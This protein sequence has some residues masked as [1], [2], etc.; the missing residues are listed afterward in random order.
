MKLK[1]DK[2]AFGIFQD[3]L[4]IK[5][6]QLGVIKGKVRIIRLE[7]TVLSHPLRGEEIPEELEELEEIEELKIPE[8]S[9]YD[10]P[11]EIEKVEEAPEDLTGKTDLQNLLV[12]FPLDKG[13]IALNANE[14][15]ISYYQFEPGYSTS[16]IK[17][18][19]R[20]EILSKEELKAKNYTFDYIYNADKSILAFVHR[21]ESELLKTLQEINLIISKK[22]FFYSFIDTNE[23]SLMNLLRGNY[24]IPSEE[25]VLILYI[26]VDYKVGIVME[27]KN[28]FKTFPII[29]TD[30]E[31]K[32]TREAIYS[33]V[34]LEQ[35]VSNIPMPQ[36]IL[37]AGDNVSKK[38]VTF[39]QKKY[40]EASVEILGIKNVT[41]DES[42]N[43]LE[44]PDKS[45]TGGL[46][47]QTEEFTKEK[48]G[49]FA[50]PIALAW[51]TLD[52]KNKALFPSNLLP[53]KIIESQKHFKIAWHGFLIVA[54]IFYF[55][56][57]STTKNITLKQ[58]ILNAQQFNRDLELEIQQK[59]N[60]I[61]TINQIRSEISVLENNIKQI[62]DLIGNK[63]QWH[64]ILN[65]LANALLENKIS[66]I[67]NLKSSEDNFQI[68]GYTTQKRNIIHFSKLFPN[69]IIESITGHLIQDL[70]IWRYDINFSYPNPKDIEKEKEESLT[71][72]QIAELTKKPPEPVIKEPIKPETFEIEV[73]EV[74]IKEIYNNIVSIYFKRNT[75]DAYE[76]FKEFI[77][78]YPDHKL[79]HN[80]NYLMGECL[81]TLGKISEAKVIFENT[82]KQKGTKTPDALMMLGNSYL[83]ENDINNAI[84]YWN[85]LVTNYPDH[86]LTII[87][88]NKINTFS[89]LD[90][91]Y[92]EKSEIKTEVTLD[93]ITEKS[94][95]EIEIS[96]TKDISAKQFDKKE[97]YELQLLSRRDYSQV[98]QDKKEMEQ[99]GYKTKIT[100]I[101]KDGD[102]FYRLRLY[103]SC[104]RSE[105]IALG[106]KIKEQFPFINNYWIEKLLYDDDILEIYHSIVNI[107]YSRN[108][109]KALEKLNE[110]AEKYPSHPLSYNA[111]YLTGEC[112]YQIGRI[113]EAKKIFE[114]TI[115]LNGNKTPDA[116]MMMGNCYKKEND[117]NRAI[118][119]WNQL[120]NTFPDNRLSKIARYKIKIFKD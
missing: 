93:E 80:A 85:Q 76:R 39:F 47:G 79:A 46:T 6:A 96:Q 118:D 75:Q 56:F 32:N 31:S 84:H 66:W 74:N 35:D 70:P 67:N 65:I 22:K 55:T 25:Y 120:I 20:V 12:N 11:E 40:P 108:H 33:K 101:T 110:F 62:E 3:G 95:K 52:P 50:I 16:G 34:M 119:Y 60:I 9:E 114:N 105:A 106:E 18:K 7:E 90:N 26:N 23:I 82:I 100:S 14:E 109:E 43:P 72:I 111:N 27:G 61:T 113:D 69:G 45:D 58:Q 36:H 59:K 38:D 83:K 88:K 71:K 49:E 73:S 89:S 24:E 91:A 48:I 97:V 44:N 8:I 98:E 10:K 2:L 57:M 116:L 1:K 53:T 15:Q 107:Y 94:K 5:V 19:I 54:A 115:R 99:F 30:T 29:V 28:H 17:K 78:K 81:Y 41:I 77:I 102:I 86:K 87:A 37:L 112:L 68:S 64:Y 92:K 104:T 103:D 13:K 4:S 42:Q 21:G 63:N 51:K 117:L